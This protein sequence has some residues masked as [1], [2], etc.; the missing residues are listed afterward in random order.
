MT[1]SS[2]S[3]FCSNTSDANFR[4]WGKAL[5]DGI[6]AAGWVADDATG[7]IDWLTVTKPTGTDEKKGFEVWATNDAKTTYYLRIDYGSDSGNEEWPAIWLTLGTTVSATGEIGGIYS[8][9]IQLGTYDP[10]NKDA[11]S[12]ICSFA[13][14][15]NWLSVSMF[16]GYHSGYSQ[17]TFCIERLK[18]TN[19]DDVDTGMSMHIIAAQAWGAKHM[20]Q[21]VIPKTGTAWSMDDVTDAYPGWPIIVSSQTRTSSQNGTTVGVYTVHPW[22]Q[23]HYAA[24]LGSVTYHLT[25]PDIPNQTSFSITRYGTSHTY[26]ALGSDCKIMTSPDL[27]LAIRYE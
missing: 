5:H 19:G 9:C 26:L 23:I 7:Q 2:V 18:D 15:N 14:G 27:A 22:A 25:I 20:I 16:Q 8:S 4:A 24:I 13:G 3:K 1:A 11:V 10:Q 12:R 17:P 6:V 21:Q